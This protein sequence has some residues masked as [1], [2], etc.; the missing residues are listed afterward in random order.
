MWGRIARQEEHQE[1]VQRVRRGVRDVVVES[2][3]EVSSDSE[4]MEGWMRFLR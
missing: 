4:R 2:R 1:A 3:R